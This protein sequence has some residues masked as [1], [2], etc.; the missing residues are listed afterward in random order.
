VGNFAL[1]SFRT[2]VR[3][4]I[5]SVDSNDIADELDVIDEALLYFRANVFFKNY[6]IQGDSDR[7]LIY[8]TLYISECLK[9]LQKATKKSLAT[10]DLHSLAIAKFDIPG[11]TSFPLPTV[12]TRPASNEEA[13]LLRQYLIQVRQEIGLR[14]CDRVFE[15]D[16]ARPSK[17]WTCFAKRRFMDISL[18]GHGL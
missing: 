7:V 9:R 8:L 15:S 3:G 14:L 13:D 11:D 10:N 2:K 1:L 17:W 16:L 6:E 5:A 12:Y 4:P 18:S